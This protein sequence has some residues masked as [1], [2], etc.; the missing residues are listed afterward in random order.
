[1]FVEYVQLNHFSELSHTT[2]VKSGRP[3][4]LLIVN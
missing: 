4:T 3:K 1:M 2:K